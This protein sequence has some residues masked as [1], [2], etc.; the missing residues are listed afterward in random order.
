MQSLQ[1][2]LLKI[3][4]SILR[5]QKVEQKPVDHSEDIRALKDEIQSLKHELKAVKKSKPTSSKAKK[6]K[7]K[8]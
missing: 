6:T 8:S 7:A 3:E 1:Q 4:A 2:R 5:L